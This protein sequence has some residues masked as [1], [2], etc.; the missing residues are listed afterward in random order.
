MSN[1]ECRM[2]GQGRGR[3]AGGEGVHPPTNFGLLTHRNKLVGGQSVVEYLVVTTAIIAIIILTV[4][5]QIALRSQ[6]L[7][8]TAINNIGR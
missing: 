3:G 4:A 2:N 5:P 6:A 1:V 8:G 7:M